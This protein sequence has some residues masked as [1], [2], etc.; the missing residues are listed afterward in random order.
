M[1]TRRAAPG[2][3]SGTRLPAPLPRHSGAG[4]REGIKESLRDQFLLPG[5]PSPAPV[6]PSR[7]ALRSREIQMT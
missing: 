3:P 4:K 6:A 7:F 2:D 5:K 1:A